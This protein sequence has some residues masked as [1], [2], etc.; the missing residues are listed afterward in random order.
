MNIGWG[1]S[2][3]VYDIGKDYGLFN[4]FSKHLRKGTEGNERAGIAQW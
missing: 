2:L 1:G 3:I 4:K